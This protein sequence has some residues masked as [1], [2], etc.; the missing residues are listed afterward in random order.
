MLLEEAINI[1]YSNGFLIDWISFYE[2]GVKKGWNDKTIIQKIKYS[3]DESDFIEY[4]DE[5]LKLLKIY[6]LKKDI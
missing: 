4:K 3:F 2:D 1:F 5:T 6:I